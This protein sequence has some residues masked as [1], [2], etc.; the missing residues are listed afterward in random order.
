[1]NLK[2]PKFYEGNIKLL[3][4][5]IKKIGIVGSRSILSQT[6]DF[7]DDLFLEIKNFN[8]CIVSGGMY[9]V[10]IYAHNLALKHKM[11]T[12]VVLPQGIDSYKKS[13]LFSQLKFSPDSNYLLSSE[14]PNNFGARKYT[15]IQ[16]NNTIAYYSDVLLVAQAS[17][18]SG[19]IT[20]AN[21]GLRQK[22][23]VL[24]VPFSLEVK[25]FQGTNHLIRKGC[26]IYLDPE[27]LLEN[28]G[29]SSN[30]IDE[31]ILSSLNNTPKNLY[32]LE[33]L[34]EVNIEVLKKSLLK[35]ILEGQIFFD[36][37]NYYL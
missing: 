16:R 17:P 12:I 7:L 35:L 19:S 3:S 8:L 10:D 13:Y 25:Q 28:I 15:F 29:I 22:K 20:T 33:K 30:Y 2:E 27:S 32:E 21:F 14:Y 24:C 31:R 26:Q 34:L 36:G 4:S 1:M 5:N 6:K 18:N 11:S 23:K 37:E 9:G